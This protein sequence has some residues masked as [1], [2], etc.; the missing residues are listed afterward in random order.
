M[1]QF[2]ILGSDVLRK[3][4]IGHSKLNSIESQKTA[5]ERIRVVVSLNKITFQLLNAGLGMF[6]ERFKIQHE[7]L[8][9]RKI[10]TKLWKT[11]YGKIIILKS[12]YALN[13]MIRV[14]FVVLS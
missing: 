13:T 14:K 2:G 3:I 7:E 6:Y 4:D 8:H 12:I 11:N 1:W 5:N 10:H 9:S